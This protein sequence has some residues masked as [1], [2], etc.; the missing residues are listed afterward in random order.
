MFKKTFTASLLSLLA[1]AFA[2]GAE[3][4]PV[5]VIGEGT[6]LG[7]GPAARSAAILDAQTTIV[8]DRLEA[9]ALSRDFTV[10]TPILEDA[11]SY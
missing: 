4:T 6:A 1:T 8:L 3:E 7:L 2:F 9:L 5:K 10:F 11:H